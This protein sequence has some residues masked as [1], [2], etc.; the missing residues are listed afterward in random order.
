MANR[1]VGVSVPQFFSFVECRM[2][3]VLFSVM[4]AMCLSN[5]I[6]SSKMMSLN[7][8]VVCR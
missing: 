2:L 5:F 7:L 4:L 8:C 6:F 1:R 3:S